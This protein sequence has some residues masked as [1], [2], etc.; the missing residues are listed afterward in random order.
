MIERFLFG[1]VVLDVKLSVPFE[2]LFLGIWNVFPQSLFSRT[3]NHLK[4][5]YLCFVE[6]NLL[7]LCE[8]VGGE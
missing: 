8:P 5:L 4:V 2:D 6:L 7:Q 3:I 1:R